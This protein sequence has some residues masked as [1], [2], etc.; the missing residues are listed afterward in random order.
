VQDRTKV[1]DVL[2]LCGFTIGAIFGG[3]DTVPMYTAFRHEVDRH[4]S[5]VSTTMRVDKVTRFVDVNNNV[6]VTSA[7]ESL[8]IHL[9]AIV[10][11][12]E[13]LDVWGLLNGGS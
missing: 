9:I 13:H 11:N 5:N 7:R 12:I 8:P 1:T 6:I 10:T 3:D 4:N 2:S